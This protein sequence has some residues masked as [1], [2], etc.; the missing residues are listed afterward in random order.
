MADAATGAAAF[1]G[2]AVAVTGTSPPSSVPPPPVKVTPTVTVTPTYSDSTITVTGHSDCRPPPTMTA[3]RSDCLPESITAIHAK[4]HHLHCCKPPRRFPPP[5]TDAGQQ[6]HPLPNHHPIIRQLNHSFNPIPKHHLPNPP[7]CPQPPL[8]LV[9]RHRRTTSDHQ[10]PG[11]TPL[12][13]QPPSSPQPSQL[14]PT[15]RPTLAQSD[16]LQLH[17]ATS[18]LRILDKTKSDMHIQSHRSTDSGQKKGEEDEIGGAR[19]TSTVLRASLCWSELQLIRPSTGKIRS[20]SDGDAP[21]QM[22]RPL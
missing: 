19:W 1:T 16:L 8:R 4:N 12:S 6:C 17:Q 15:P 20:S 22:D 7:V 11:P 2:T 13:P 14:P 10:T 18:D 5:A 3:S 9:C 21:P